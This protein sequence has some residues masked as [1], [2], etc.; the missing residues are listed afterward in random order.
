MILRPAAILLLCYGL[1]HL[2]RPLLKQYS[3][4]FVLFGAVT[5]L[6]VLHLV[7]LPPS[8]W[9]PL[10][11]RDLLKQIDMAAGLGHIHR[12]LSVAP[13][14][15][16][17]ALYSLAVPAAVLVTAAQLKLA[18]QMRLMIGL[19]VFILAS[20]V[21]TVA[22]ATGSDVAFYGVT[23]TT[24]GIFANRN[25][26]SALIA[27][28]FPV[29]ASARYF[30]TRV[31]MM[32][33]R[34]A[35]ILSI[36]LGLSLVPLV[37]IIGSRTGLVLCFIAIALLATIV[38]GQINGSSHSKK[39]GAAAVK[40]IG[41][42]VAVGSMVWLTFAASR[43]VAFTRL[44][45]AQEDGR[46]AIWRGV[47]NDLP[48]WMPWGSG[49]GSFADAYQINESKWVLGPK[50]LN[51]AHN[52]WLEVVYTTGVPGCVLLVAGC[53]LFLAGLWRLRGTHGRASTLARCGIVI[54]FLLALASITDYPIRTPIMASIMSL[55]AIW[56]CFPQEDRK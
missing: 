31:G 53:A 37:I 17:N 21:V 10:P 20:S 56:S 18:D 6:V 16:W 41:A 5:A 14:A 43:D 29:L 11:T 34:L 13:D 24:P 12:P 22:Q 3:S 46:S 47:A 51:H 36:A 27:I 33:G 49:V 26:Q 2:D 48:N 42:A 55:A 40:W 28:A 23:S 32:N 50:F 8:M 15:T 54:I 9:Q 35:N 39:F 1:T 45:D 7:P 52:D 44:G 25:H 30:A 19:L 4:V 38:P